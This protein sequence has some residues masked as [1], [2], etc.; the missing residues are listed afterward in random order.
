MATGDEYF[1]NLLKATIAYTGERN[2]AQNVFYLACTAAHG[3]GLDALNT[4]AQAIA[5][6][7]S[8]VVMPYISS[9]ISMDYV[10][11]ADWTDATGLTGLYDI[12]TSGGLSGNALPS[13][14]CTLLNYETNLRYRGG[15]GRMYLPQPSGAELVND[16]TWSSTF[17]GNVE[18]AMATFFGY[19]NEQTLASAG[20]NWVL[21]HRGTEH[22]AQGFEDVLS[23]ICSPTPGTQRRRVRRVGHKR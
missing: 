1:E 18:A 17:I 11:V 19:V 23:I 4:L 22:V 9:G 20:M 12:D 13:Q 5:A 7:F 6:E 15:R 16:H 8:S 14:V 2:T 21:Y 3:A 10:S